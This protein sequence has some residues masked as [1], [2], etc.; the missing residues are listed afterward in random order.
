MLFASVYLRMNKLQM[1]FREE[2]SDAYEA[3][4]SFGQSLALARK[5]ARTGQPQRALDLASDALSLAR[6]DAEPRRIAEAAEAVAA[7]HLAASS[8]PDALAL[9][10]EALGLWKDVGNCHAQVRC[11]RAAADVDLHVGDYARSLGR[12]EEALGLLEEH[13]DADAKA[14]ILHGLGMVYTRLGE[15]GRARE[16]NEL[17]LTHR[18]EKGDETAIATSLNSLGVLCLRTGEHRQQFEPAAAA[19]D[20]TRAKDYFE[21]AEQLAARSGEPHLQALALGNIGSALGFLGDLEHAMTHFE[22]QLAALRSMRDRNNESLCLANIAE[23]LRLT[24][25]C[26][27]AIETLEQALAI[28]SAVQSKARMMRVHLELSRCF[29]DQ[30]NMSRALAHYKQ[31]HKLDQELRSNDAEEKANALVVRMA[32]RKVREEAETYRAERDRLAAANVELVEAAH[33]DVLTGLGNRR[34]LDAQLAPLFDEMRAAERPLS[35]ALADIDHFKAINDRFSHTTGD[36]VLRTVGKLLRAACRPSDIAVRYGGEEFVLTL[37][38]ATLAQARAAC[39]RLRAAVAGY[40]WSA[41]HPDLKVTISI[42]VVERS[43]HSAIAPML[44]A[45]DLQL[46]EAKRAG[47]NCVR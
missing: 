17:A 26:D 22:R 28:G 36:D 24:G 25:R 45:A 33:V 31:Y 38:E 15:L 5:L 6:R 42:G 2:P 40:N 9:Y 47:R 35:V 10:L 11:M 21:E 20:F 14:S 7:A 4:S 18:R 34:Y 19:A 32:V 41:I 1:Q 30:A 12:L 3:N 16:F 27:K 23:A 39:Q 44:A 29:E 13:P 37:P 8:Y 46:Y 43:S